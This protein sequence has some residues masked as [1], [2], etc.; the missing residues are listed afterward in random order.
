VLPGDR[1]HLGETPVGVER[2]AG[3]RRAV[4]AEVK[5]ASAWVPVCALRVKVERLT[6]APSA[7]ARTVVRLKGVSPGQTASAG[8]K[9]R[10]MSMRLMGRLL[11]IVELVGVSLPWREV[12][13]TTGEILQA[14]GT[15]A[16]C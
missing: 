10:E 7:M 12:F 14:K 1:D 8:C 5:R 3:K 16:G 4:V 9:V 13:G 11:E 15:G 6:D 2:Q